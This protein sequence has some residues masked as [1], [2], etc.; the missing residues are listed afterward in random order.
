MIEE[1]LGANGDLYYRDVVIDEERM[2]EFRTA[3]VAEQMVR[4]LG[5][6]YSTPEPAA[7]RGG[8]R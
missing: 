6:L 7:T 4:L 8:A 5:P 2:P 3:F 1:I